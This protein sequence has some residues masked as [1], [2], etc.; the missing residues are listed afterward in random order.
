MGYWYITCLPVKRLF[1]ALSFEPFAMSATKAGSRK[2]VSESE[3]TKSD[4]NSRSATDN[5]DLDLDFDLSDD[6]KGIVSALHLIRDKAQKD[7]QK[8]NEETI[9]S[10]ASEIKSMIEGLSAK[11]E[12][13]RQ[14][15][16][17]ALSKS[18]KEYE[19]SLKNEAAKFQALHENFSKEKA[20]SL[21]ALKDIISK[22]EG[23]KEKLFVRYEQLRKKER[24]MISEQEKACN[25]KIVQLEDSLKKKKQDDKTFSILRKTLGSFLESTSDEDFP[26]DD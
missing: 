13:D 7:G 16:A 19:S 1:S 3:R 21:Q 24:I 10:V 8:K 4:K 20:T 5:F 14:S 12:K 25:D 9:S 2:R 11:I 15:F 22:F 6:I 18:S 26:P 23:E 17:K